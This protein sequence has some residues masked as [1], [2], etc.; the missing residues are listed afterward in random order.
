MTTSELYL[1]Q[2]QINIQHLL[3]VNY[4]FLQELIMYLC[5]CMYTEP[6]T[7]THIQGEYV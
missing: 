6:H 4:V 7:Y 2:F 3:R 1:T 5:V